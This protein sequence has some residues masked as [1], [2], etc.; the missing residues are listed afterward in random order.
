MSGH[1]RSSYLRERL[2]SRLTSL[3][4]RAFSWPLSKLHREILRSLKEFTGSEFAAIGLWDEDKKCWYFPDFSDPL[5]KNCQLG[6]VTRLQ[7]LGGVFEKALREGTTYISNHLESDPHYKGIPPGHVP[8]KRV[9]IRPILK[10]KEPRGILVVANAPRCYGRYEREALEKIACFY[11]LLLEA[12]GKENDLC[13]GAFFFENGVL[14]AQRAKTLNILV[15]NLAHK[16]NNLLNVIWASLEFTKMKKERAG[17][18]PFLE[19]AEAATQELSHLVKQLLLYARGEC[20]GKKI[21]KLNEFLPEVFRFLRTILPMHIKLVTRVP[22]DLPPVRM[23][24]MALEHV[25]VN[26]VVNAAEAY[27]ET[28]GMVSIQLEVT[29]NHRHLRKTRGLYRVRLCSGVPASRW[30]AIRV[31]DRGPGI[32]PEALARITEPFYSTKGLGRGLGLAAVRNIVWAH[33]GCLSIYSRPGKG[34]LFKVL[35]PVNGKEDS[36]P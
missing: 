6:G 31:K 10:G 22:K 14:E 30:V 36:T 3:L 16:F 32:P 17:L 28:P 33:D 21:L 15:G 1:K 13:P 24:P 5:Y 9:A 4:N 19:K 8:I 25:L 26:L 12:K 20:L 18:E 35:L 2:D 27:G 7:R 34:T 23:D 11:G 29:E